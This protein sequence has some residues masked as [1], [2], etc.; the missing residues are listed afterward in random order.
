MKKVV[1][2]GIGIVA[3]N[4][5]GTEYVWKN[6]VNGV[7]GVRTIDT[8]DTSDLQCHIAGLPIRGTEPGQYNPDK[9]VDV[10]D[11][12]KLDRSM[13]YGIVAADDL[14]RSSRS[15][16]SQMYLLTISWAAALSFATTYTT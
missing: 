12:R 5:T 2:T 9:I 14:I 3:P 4:G 16:L 1:I 10:R 6:V 15:Y 8:F 7:S 13:I 11:Q